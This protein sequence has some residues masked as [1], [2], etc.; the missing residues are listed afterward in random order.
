MD[1]ALFLKL[2]ESVDW[3]RILRSPKGESSF[4]FLC[5]GMDEDTHTDKNTHI[6]THAPRNMYIIHMQIQYTH[7]ETNNINM[8][9]HTEK[10]E[11]KKR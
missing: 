1:M 8:H 2:S 6:Y 7:T 9:E 3:D 5:R 11:K 4:R 10:N